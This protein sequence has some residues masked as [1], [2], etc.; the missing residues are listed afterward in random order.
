MSVNNDTRDKI[1]QQAES[2]I[3]QKGYTGLSLSELCSELQLSKA[4]WFYHF[5]TKEKMLD[6][7]ITKAIQESNY[8]IIIKLFIEFYCNPE[9]VEHWDRL[10]YDLRNSDWDQVRNIF[11]SYIYHPENKFSLEEREKIHE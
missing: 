3:L 4:T 8:N 1:L 2:I 7:I 11:F 6:C 5:S 10:H 9:M